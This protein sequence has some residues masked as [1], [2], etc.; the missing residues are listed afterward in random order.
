MRPHTLYAS[1][2]CEQRNSSPQPELRAILHT[3]PCP[4][5]LVR[6]SL[7]SPSPVS[8]SPPAPLAFSRDQQMKSSPEPVW[9]QHRRIK[10]EKEKEK[11][12]EKDGSGTRGASESAASR[13]SL[14]R[15]GNRESQIQTGRKLTQR[16]G[17]A[18]AEG[19]FNK[20]E[21]LEVLRKVG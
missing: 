5:S 16:L 21:V 17:K 4:A 3:P 12:K 9:K 8:L 14:G 6:F 20:E 15:G 19:K 7:S 10:E 13:S 11:G 1:L 2:H 18:S